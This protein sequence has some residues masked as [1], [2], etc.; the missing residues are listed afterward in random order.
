MRL[1]SRDT[2][3]RLPSGRA[4]RSLASFTARLRNPAMRQSCPRSS[5]AILHGL[6]RLA[7]ARTQRAQAARNIELGAVGAAHDSR[8]SSIEVGVLSPSHRSAPA[9]AGMHPAT[10]RV[11][12]RGARRTACRVRGCSGSK[13]RDSPSV[14]SFHGHKGYAH[15]WHHRIRVNA[16][17]PAAA[18]RWAPIYRAV[19]TGTAAM[20]RHSTALPG[21]STTHRARSMSASYSTWQLK[22]LLKYQNQF[23]PK[24]WR[25]GPQKL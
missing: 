21:G 23:E 15:G 13:P 8:T 9:R 1:R 14:T 7:N 2:T 10:H 11:D 22:G 12:R 4:L 19:G 17:R 24:R 25:P 20:Y 6:K 18:V 5:T 3:R 16:A